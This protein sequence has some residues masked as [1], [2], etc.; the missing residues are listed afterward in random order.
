MPAAWWNRKSAAVGPSPNAQHN[1]DAHVDMFS[2]TVYDQPPQET[3]GQKLRRTIL[4]KY[5]LGAAVLVAIA[6]I[7]GLS[8]GLQHRKSVG[9]QTRHRHNRVFT[10]AAR[11]RTASVA[12]FCWRLDC[13]CSALLCFPFVGLLC[14]YADQHCSAG[15]QLASAICQG[16]CML[17][18]L[19]RVSSLGYALY[20]CRTSILVCLLPRI[21]CCL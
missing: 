6:L 8:V 11:C 2:T 5:W 10:Q 21:K 14:Y 12:I 7:V 19:P 1:N 9:T 13:L 17:F 20:W 15:A 4:N 3:K 16:Q 18:T